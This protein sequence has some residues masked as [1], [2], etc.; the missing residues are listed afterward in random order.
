MPQ[1]NIAVIILSAVISLACYDKAQRNRYTTVFSTAMNEI[2]T[3]YIDV[4]PRRKLFDAA[5]TGMVDALDDQYSSY[6]SPEDFRQFQV[7]IDQEF[8]GVGIEVMLDKDTERLTVISPLVGTPAYLAGVR[9]G[10]VMPTSSP[11]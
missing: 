6:I 5:M 2:S 10:D 7:D 1:H 8:G 3:R 4:V 11:N 9:T